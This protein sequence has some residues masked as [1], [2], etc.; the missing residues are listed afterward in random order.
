MT[1]PLAVACNRRVREY[2]NTLTGLIWITG[3]TH[4]FPTNHPGIVI[5]LCSPKTPFSIFAELDIHP[6]DHFSRSNSQ[7]RFTAPVGQNKQL[8][9]VY[10]LT[11]SVCFL[12]LWTSKI[13]S[14]PVPGK[15]LDQPHTFIIVS[16]SWSD[17]T[18]VELRRSPSRIHYF[19]R[20]PLAPTIFLCRYAL[21]TWPK[22]LAPLVLS[23]FDDSE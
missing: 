8:R 7:L 12:G 9:A 6:D 13:G 18:H 19:F 4:L 3:P 22:R 10:A 14:L 2:S 21:W 1:Q 17:C 5:S 11:I 23:P 16:V 15:D 20:S